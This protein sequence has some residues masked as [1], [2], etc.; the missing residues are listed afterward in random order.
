M[1]PLYI[2][3]L[4]GTIANV[5]HR[6][7]LL[8][9]GSKTRW[10]EF[11]NACDKDT[12]NIPVIRTMH[13]LQAQGAEIWIFSGRTETVREKTRH[14][15]IMNTLLP[16]RLLAET[17]VMRPVGDHRPDDELKQ[18]FLDRMLLED[19]ERLVAVFDD[20][21]RVVK[22]WRKNGI[23]CFQVAEGNF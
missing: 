6:L 20:R 8:N 15:L 12:P 2:F 11:Y 9:T 5:E 4:D 14:W 18:Q 7:W 16:W 23:T 3:D 17:L 19:R 22:M 13:A 1:R 10:D 21:D